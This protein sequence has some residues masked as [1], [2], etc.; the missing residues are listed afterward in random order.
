MKVIPSYLSGQTIL[1]EREEKRWYQC[2][3]SLAQ[4]AVAYHFPARTV[5]YAF[6][7]CCGNAR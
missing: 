7:F 2:K 5:L 3:K 1:E 6:Q 4:C